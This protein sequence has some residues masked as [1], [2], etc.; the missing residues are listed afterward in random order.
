MVR[1]RHSERGA[2]LVL[3]LALLLALGF[4][5]AALIYT[6]GGDLKVSGQDRRGTQAQF[7]AEA[8]VQEALNRLSLRPGTD[9]TVNSE[10]FDACIRDTV[11]GLDPDWE[12]DVYAPGGATP[13]SANPN[14]G[15]TPTVQDLASN[16]LDYLREGQLV[17]IRHKWRD[18]N[19]DSVRD[20]GEIVRYDA[21]RIPP[22]NT[23]EG[24]VI[25]VIEVAGHST[26]ARR[27]LR[28]E[29][30]RF[31]FTPNLLAAL[32]CN[33]GA[34][35]R[36]TVNVCGH[37][38]RIDTPENSNLE[39]VPPCSAFDEGYDDLPAVMTTGDP[40]LT[41]GSTNLEGVPAA[42][43]TVSTNP[44]YSLAEALGVTQD[45][46]DMILADPD[47]T[48]SRDGNPLEGITYIAGD[49]TGGEKFNSTSGEGLLYVKG[50]LDISGGFWWRGLVY[51]EGDIKITGNAWV[52]GAIMCQGKSEYGIGGGNPTVL[53]SRDAIRLAL[54][55][56]FD[57]IVISWKE[58]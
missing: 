13:T 11:P 39:S 14:A 55:L 43:D 49:A 52:L 3:A 37:N 25:E 28:V 16:P 27:R 20:A 26:E 40:V 57:Y 53:Y 38:H 32:N 56:A 15:F 36:G 54:E 34:D 21:S 17:T 19:G 18:L 1:A 44:F 48:S 31:P 23:T 47:H 12:V 50:D 9:V 58:L 51:V 24:S 30:T 7:A 33:T 10:T 8:G 2:A 46:V 42:M 4:V 35:L 5:G 45:V 29:V 6:A 41:G 22:E